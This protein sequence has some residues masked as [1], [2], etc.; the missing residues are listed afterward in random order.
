MMICSAV[1]TVS[2][3]N[4]QLEWPG[5][6]TCAD[7]NGLTEAQVETYITNAPLDLASGTTMGGLDLLT[8]ADQGV[9]LSD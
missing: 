7:D 2:R 9:A 1:S 3:S 8:T 5:L 6:W 4:H